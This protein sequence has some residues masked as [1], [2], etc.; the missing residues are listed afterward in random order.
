MD[1]TTSIF[2]KNQCQYLSFG[3]RLVQ[4]VR[5]WL[6]RIVV[7]DPQVAGVVVPT[8][9]RTVSFWERYPAIGTP[10]F[11]HTAYVQAE[12]SVWG[13]SGVAF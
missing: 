10:S 6:D 12:S 5:Q 11:P 7:R 4:P 3:D 9:T 13:I 8:Y 1:S 2:S